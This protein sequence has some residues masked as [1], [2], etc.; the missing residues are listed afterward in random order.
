MSDVNY[1]TWLLG[2]PLA[3]QAAE[4]AYIKHRRISGTTSKKKLKIKKGCLV[5]V[6]DGEGQPWQR[7]LNKKQN[8]VT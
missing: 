6:T 1:L 2:F 4:L 3:Y 8:H 7:L 5:K